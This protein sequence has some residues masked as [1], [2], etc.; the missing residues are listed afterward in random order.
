M[1]VTFNP[2]EYNYAS[3]RN[4]VYG[5]KGM[6]CTS[7]PL[8][9]QAG[10]DI[11]KKGGNAI[12]AA[13]ATAAAMTV[14]EPTSNGIG[15]DAFALI[16]TEGELKGLNASGP[17]PDAIVPEEIKEKF[18]SA[19]PARGWVPVTVP[20][21]PAA[22]AVMSEKY[23]KLPF[24]ELMKPA[25]EYAE[26]GFPLAPNTAILWERAFNDFTKIFKDDY[27][28]HWFETFTPNNKAPK[29]GEV[30]YL[31]DHAKTLKEI[32]ETKAE[33]FYRGAL[34]DKIDAFSRETG[35][36][37]RKSDLE[38]FY[39]EWVKPISTDYRGFRVY[40]IPPNGHGITAL[41]ALNIYENYQKQGA[42]NLESYHQQIEAMKLAFV[43]AQNYVTDPRFM[44]VSAEQLLSKKYAKQR[45]DLIHD[46][47]LTPEVGDPTQAGTIYLA[48][49]DSEGN[50]VSFI[51][52][53]YMG[54]GSGLVVPNTG[55]GLH[56][57]GNNFSL[58]PE[59][60]NF[61]AP[62]KKPY[63]TIIPAFLG[64]GDKPVGPFGVMGG[65]MQP[66]GHF[67]V[68]VNTVDLHMN[69]QQALDA[70]RWQ[71]VGGKKIEVERD[72]PYGVTEELAR[73]GHE[74]SVVTDSIAMGRGQIIW[75]DEET[76]VLV[77]GTE[78]RADGT[79]AAW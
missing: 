39:P 55:I 20:G 15:G 19:M 9:A 78:K 3:K 43:D 2:L 61:I 31:K 62:G 59:K 71:W 26:N 42:L 66:Q 54:F 22:W 40:E 35:G 64:K 49:A 47:A 69:P 34:A 44:S 52:S 6:V 27:F 32:G 24:E 18:G 51:Q 21:A 30:V 12:D 68:V 25:I 77:G 13:I 5:K 46:K 1:S 58:D 57:R 74:M 48:T 45:F 17:A 36:Y 65:F 73:R 50:M 76:G 67:Q 53:N 8:A 79:V 63:H 14:L 33:S 60:D 16:W 56:N 7:Q 11:L 75:R 70:P 28:K 37:L 29:A 4:V 10:L 23:G 72:F 41:M 38:K